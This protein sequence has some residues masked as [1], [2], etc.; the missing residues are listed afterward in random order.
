VSLK[1]PKLNLPDV[2]LRIKQE[3][4]QNKIFDPIRKKWLLLTPEEHVR[5]SFLLYMNQVNDYP[6]GL[7]ETEKQVTLNNTIKRADIVFYDQR[8]KTRVIVECK[9]PKIKINNEVFEQVSRYHFALAADVLIVTN[10]L[11]HFAFKMDKEKIQFL[12]EIPNFNSFSDIT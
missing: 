12:N 8:L 10:G 9:A 2:P 5:Q 6:L 4:G 1:L 11:E 3:D 7:T